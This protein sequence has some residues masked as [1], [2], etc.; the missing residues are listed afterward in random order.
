MSNGSNGVPEVNWTWWTSLNI[1][2][3]YY[4]PGLHDALL[5]I[6]RE[7]IDSYVDGKEP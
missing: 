2:T 5:A 7:T 3:I 1:S 6:P 4:H